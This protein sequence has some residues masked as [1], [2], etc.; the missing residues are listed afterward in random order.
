MAGV[1]RVW[2][3]VAYA[4]QAPLSKL[5]YGCGMGLAGWC[6]RGDKK[7][8]QLHL[9]ISKGVLICRGIMFLKS[10][11]RLS[12][13]AWIIVTAGQLIPVVSDDDA[14]DDADAAYWY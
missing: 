3:P 4:H 6:A 1:V 2:S 8:R 12:V 11:M 10:L 14:R 9:R 13:I 7:H 5:E